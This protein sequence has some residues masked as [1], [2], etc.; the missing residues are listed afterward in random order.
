[1]NV[2]VVLLE[3]AADNEV[4]GVY[5]T[6]KLAKSAVTDYVE[7]HDSAVF[8]RKQK[9]DVLKR[10][11]F[12]EDTKENPRHLS[13]TK[14]PFALP[15]KNNKK[16]RDP[17]LPRKGLSAYM[18]F[19]QENRDKI[20]EAN[21]TATFGEIGK[22]VGESWRELDDKKRLVYTKKSDVDKERYTKA[23]EQYKATELVVAKPAVD[24]PAVI[25]ETVVSETATE[26][27]QK[28]VTRKKAESVVA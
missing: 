17:N 12:V 23:M 10:T 21:P 2:F 6:E 11:L 26:V 8:K 19:A 13:V 9:K 25:V 28:R 1:M 15:V 14:V 3:S 7:S 27:K 5:L 16:T 22:F 20:K 4:L 24:E 18:I